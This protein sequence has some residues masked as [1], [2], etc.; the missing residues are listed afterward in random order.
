MIFNTVPSPERTHTIAFVLSTHHEL[1][2]IK[3]TNIELKRAGWM[4]L[5]TACG[6]ETVTFKQQHVPGPIQKDRYSGV[7]YYIRM[8]YVLS[9]VTD[10]VWII[11]QPQY[12]RPDQVPQLMPSRISSDTSYWREGLSVC[13][14]YQ[15]K[16]QVN[17]WRVIKLSEELGSVS[18]QAPTCSEEICRA[19]ISPPVL[20]ELKKPTLSVLPSVP[21][22]SIW[23]S[24]QKLLVIHLN[25]NWF[26]SYVCSQ[27][28]INLEIQ[29]AAAIPL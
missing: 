1:P 10:C 13:A 19:R 23:F 18:P 21:M 28:R 9:V 14:S 11:F 24:K 7:R 6:S 29:H 20:L 25:L 12:L 22:E 26:S 16:W 2:G 8:L 15:H 5:K 27:T 4:R 3:S 17:W